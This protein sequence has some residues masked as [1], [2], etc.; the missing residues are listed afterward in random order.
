MDLAQEL[1]KEQRR[2]NDAML[3]EMQAGHHRIVG[4]LEKKNGDDDKRHVEAQA[5]IN[6]LRDAVN[7]LDKTVKDPPHGGIQKLVAWFDSMPTV[8]SALANALVL[9]ISAAGLAAVAYF[10]F[11]QMK[12]SPT[13][14]PVETVEVVPAEASPS[15]PPP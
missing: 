13:P 10:T 15:E 14:T 5:N 8:K 4:A 7:N 6:S 3:E 9:V 2:A 1:L 11:Y 12:W